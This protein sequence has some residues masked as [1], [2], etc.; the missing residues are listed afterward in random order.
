MKQTGII[1]A[2]FRAKGYGF[3]KTGE[4]NRFF[5]VSNYNGVPRLGEPVS[6]EL[7]DPTKL[8][9][10]QQAVNVTPLEGSHAPKAGA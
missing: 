10:P 7:A 4:G 5:H 3:I 1:E 8:G 2:Y 6:F 9:Q